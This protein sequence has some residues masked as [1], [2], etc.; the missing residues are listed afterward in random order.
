[1]PPFMTSQNTIL[2]A[3][4][5]AFVVVTTQSFMLIAILKR[6]KVKASG[7]FYN[8]GFE[9]EASDQADEKQQPPKD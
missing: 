5:F 6:R 3:C 9:I 4:V 2:C 1:M 8:F 7:W